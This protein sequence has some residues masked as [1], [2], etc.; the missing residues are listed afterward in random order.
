MNEMPNNNFNN[1]PFGQDEGERQ[2]EDFLSKSGIGDRISSA[3]LRASIMRNRAKIK[4]K[5][6]F[7]KYR[8]QNFRLDPVDNMAVKAFFDSNALRNELEQDTTKIELQTN[9]VWKI[10]NEKIELLKQGTI[11]Q[12]WLS[13]SHNGIEYM[14]EIRRVLQSFEPNQNEANYVIELTHYTKGQQ[15][16]NNSRVFYKEANQGSSKQYSM[17]VSTKFNFFKNPSFGIL[18]T[19][20]IYDLGQ[21]QKEG[22][23][24]TSF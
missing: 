13:Y 3:L 9:P 22:I 4:Q 14:D 21:A 10:L 20:N 16:S 15:E 6:G 7:D 19:M 12:I 5:M 1:Q 11:N 18:F 2:I 23:S 17:F 24:I 8:Q